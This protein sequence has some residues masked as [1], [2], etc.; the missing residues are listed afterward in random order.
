MVDM[1]KKLRQII[2]LVLVL[3]MFF[4]YGAVSASY[5]PASYAVAAVAGLEELIQST[6]PEEIQGEEATCHPEL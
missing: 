1:M 6:E 3:V 5:E 2:S 4:D